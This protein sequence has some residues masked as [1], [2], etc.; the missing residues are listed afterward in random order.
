MFSQRSSSSSV[1]HSQK[2][3]QQETKQNVMQNSSRSAHSLHGTG[4]QLGSSNIRVVIINNSHNASSSAS[5]S[6]TPM[7]GLLHQN[8]MNLKQGNQ[9]PK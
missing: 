9:I 2:H 7:V 4:M 1:L 3:L 6:R 5:T 8:L